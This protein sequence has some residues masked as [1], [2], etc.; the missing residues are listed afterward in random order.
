M[1]SPRSL[2]VLVPVLALAAIACGDLTKP[3]ASYANTFAS[4]TLYA[5]PNAPANSYSAISFLGGATRTDG[6]FAFDVTLDIDSAGSAKVLPVRT[7]GGSLAGSLKRVGMQIVPGTFESLR[8]A[9]STGYDTLKVQTLRPGQ[10]VAVEL[11]D[12]QSCLYS[13]GGSMIYAKL[14]VDSVNTT[15]RRIFG[16]TVVDP[17]CGYRQVMP[18]TIPTN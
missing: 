9:P 12:F 4:Y 13:L 7:V 6:S 17:N 3:K 11:Q 15:T 16:R 14:T 2:R 8:E 10:V 5:Y 18:D 1:P